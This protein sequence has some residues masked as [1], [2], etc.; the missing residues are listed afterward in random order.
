MKNLKLKNCQKI[1][2]CISVLEALLLGACD[3][4][5][6]QEGFEVKFLLGS[7]LKEFCN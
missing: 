7:A 4:G 1:S 6:S 2:V 5:N 3:S